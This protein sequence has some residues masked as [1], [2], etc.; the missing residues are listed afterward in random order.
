MINEILYSNKDYKLVIKDL[1]EHKKSLGEELTH[2][3]L[4]GHMDI[5]STYLSKFFNQENSHLKDET[6]FKLGNILGLTDE[7]SDFLT[8]LK[9]HSTAS[10][11]ERKNFLWSKIQDKKRSQLKKNKIGQSEGIKLETMYLIKP[12]GVLVQLALDIPQYRQNPRLICAPLGISISELL[13]YLDLIEKNGFIERSEDPFEIL[14]VIDV[15]LHF[16]HSDI[17]RIHQSLFKN[18]LTMKLQ[19]TPEQDKKSFML[20]FNMDEEAFKQCNERFD[21]FIEDVKKI[22]M[23]SRQEGVYGLNFDL[24]KWL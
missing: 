17:M 9:N 10:T 5:Q 1:L 3:Q 23:K 6:L 22:V 2:K 20:S 11:P 24:M 19:E 21:A 18:L 7:E 8:L 13:E 12:K 14:K 15:D 16:A 4:A